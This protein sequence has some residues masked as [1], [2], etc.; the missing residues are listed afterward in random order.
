MDQRAEEDGQIMIW[1]EAKGRTRNEKKIASQ[2]GMSCSPGAGSGQTGQ[3][4]LVSNCLFSRQSK[5]EGVHGVEEAVNHQ[6]PD[7]KGRSDRKEK[8]E[9]D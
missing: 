4:A 7:K 9:W 3:D 1:P 2:A 5:R 8:N 6:K